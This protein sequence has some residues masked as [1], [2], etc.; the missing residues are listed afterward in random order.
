MA[1][2]K[3]KKTTTANTAA[4]KTPPTKKTATNKTTPSRDKPTTTTTSHKTTKTK[5][6]APMILRTRSEPTY[7]DIARRAYVLFEARGY[8]HGHHLEDWARAEQELRASR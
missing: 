3:N 6:E 5:V 2:C 4:K 1:T 7:E 8:A